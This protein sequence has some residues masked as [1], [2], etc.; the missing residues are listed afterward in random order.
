LPLESIALLN[1]FQLSFFLSKTRFLQFS[2]FGPS[3]LCLRQQGAT[4]QTRDR[5]TDAAQLV[6][7][8]LRSARVQLNPERNERENKRAKRPGQTQAQAEAQAQPHEQAHTG[9]RTDGQTGNRERT[10]ALCSPASLSLS[11]GRPR[12]GEL[13]HRAGERTVIGG[14]GNKDSYKHSIRLIFSK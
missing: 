3:F 12:F 8:C 7:L 13:E 10:S 5:Q 9:G 1:L 2:R 4:V 6:L 11:F 14:W